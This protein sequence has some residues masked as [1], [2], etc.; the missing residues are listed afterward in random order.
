MESNEIKILFLH[1]KHFYNHS[2]LYYIFPNC[3]SVIAILSLISTEVAKDGSIGPNDLF[4]KV[5][6]NTSVSTNGRYISA[7]ECCLLKWKI[8]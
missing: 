2:Y 8:S 7:S 6:C 4:H 3:K 5:G 1:K